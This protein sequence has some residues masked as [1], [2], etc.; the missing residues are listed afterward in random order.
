[1]NS[2][3]ANN[4]NLPDLLSRLGHTPV[5]VKKGGNELWYHSPF[6]EEKEA[7]F[8]ISKGDKWNWVWKDFGD[9]GGTVIDFIMRYQGHRDLKR[10][11]AFLDGMYQG[12]KLFQPKRQARQATQSSASQLSLFSFHGQ[13][14]AKP[15]KISETPGLEFLSARPV[16][17]TVII[18]Y[19][20]GRGIPDVLI[21]R[22]LLEIR[23]RNTQ[24]KR[25]YFAFGMENVNGGFE[26]RAASDQYQFKSALKCRDISVIPGHS[27]TEVAVFEGMTD[28][29]SFL[30]LSKQ[31]EPL[32]DCIVM[33]SLSSLRRTMAHIEKQ[34]YKRVYTWLDNNPAGLEHTE[35][36][37]K[38]LEEGRVVPQSALFAPHTDLND[39][40][41]AGLALP[42]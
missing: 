24:N 32:H 42:D 8:H 9:E 35:K 19:L 41:L 28:F 13:N 34:R 10:V 39:A 22:Y 14:A 26:I 6:R 5:A 20:K 15:P 38:K 21:Q 16:Q 12:P 4:L 27:P 23:Y 7:S 17:H 18:A 3:Q 30:V 1:M 2:F 31:E 29:L 36:F 11:L 33:H 37:I 25:E 40:L